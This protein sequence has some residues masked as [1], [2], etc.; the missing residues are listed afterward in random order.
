MGP[1]ISPPKRP[2]RLLNPWPNTK[3]TGG[4]RMCALAYAPDTA[5]P[6]HPSVQINFNLS[7]SPIYIPY[8]RSSSFSS[9]SS[10]LVNFYFCVGAFNWL[11]DPLR[12]NPHPPRPAN[13]ICSSLSL[14]LSAIFNLYLDI[15]FFLDQWNIIRWLT[16]FYPNFW[17][18]KLEKVKK[19]GNK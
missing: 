1:H 10:S 18:C 6:S 14:F 2:I 15:F 5:H 13:D 16:D 3:T 11:F 17:M 9:P 19:L 7:G 4:K 8:S 12:V